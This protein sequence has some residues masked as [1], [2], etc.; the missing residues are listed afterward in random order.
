M[1][2]LYI[3]VINAVALFLAS[4]ALESFS[5]GAAW[6]TPAI[7]AAI[8]TL[9]N[10]VVKPIAKLLSFPLVFFS[11]GLFLIVINAGILWLTEYIITVM[12]IEGVTMKIDNLLTYILAAIIFGLANWILHWFFKE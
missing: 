3:I 11:A 12:D 8:I 2:I 4:V 7:A 1:R 10:A 5:F 6:Y 9:L